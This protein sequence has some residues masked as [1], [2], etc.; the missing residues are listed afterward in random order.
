MD[1][2]F[3]SKLREL[4]RNN[5]TAHR[6][7]QL[8]ETGTISYEEWSAKGILAL[9]EQNDVYFKAA[10]DAEMRAYPKPMILPQS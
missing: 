8:W 7:V 6:L 2:E 3:Y 5:A 4:A 10:V 9:V 1:P